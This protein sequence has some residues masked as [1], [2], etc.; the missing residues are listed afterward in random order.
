V[1]VFEAIDPDPDPGASGKAYLTISLNNA[2]ALPYNSAYL[3]ER[4]RTKKELNGIRA[5]TPN[6]LYMNTESLVIPAD[7]NI[8]VIHTRNSGGYIDGSFYITTFVEFDSPILYTPSFGKYEIR[9][10]YYAITGFV[11]KV[12]DTEQSVEDVKITFYET[13]NTAMLT[14]AVKISNVTLEANNWTF[15]N[16]AD[17]YVQQVSVGNITYNTM[18]DISLT[19]AQMVI[20]KQKDITF[21]PVNDNKVIKVYCIGQKPT[22]DYTVQMKFTEVSKI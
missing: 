15:D 2:T 8:T 3:V 19:V 13:A 4:F 16:A 9:P 1:V 5:T 7:T 11:E 21:I 6:G 22:N 12:S 17:T 20:F 10:G 14:E 18:V